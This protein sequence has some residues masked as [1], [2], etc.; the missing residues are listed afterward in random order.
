MG[1]KTMLNSVVRKGLFILIGVV[2]LAGLTTPVQAVPITFNFTGTVTGVDSSL[3]PT[4]STG[5]TLTG[6]YTFESTT[7]PRAG[8]DSSFAVYDA[9]TAV[10]FSIGS[11]SASS[12]AAPEI[13]IDNAPGAPN[14]RY[15]L[16]SRASDG[17]T[18]PAVNGNTLGAF[19]FRLD[20]VNN[21]VF[22]T[23]LSLPTSLSLQ[24]FTSNSFF[25]FFGDFSITGTLN[26]LS[27]AAP[28]P[29]PSTFFLLG[30]GLSGIGFL[31]RR[32]RS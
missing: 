22:S 31:R 30:A 9:L 25:V 5:Q 24:D 17:L 8:S 4:F 19:L 6:S 18:G 27:S 16:V 13:Q 1:I 23:A 26:S 7:P 28:V 11:Y 3:S 29:E 12:T 2:A 10:N 32:F 14:D 15:G 21:A 20:D